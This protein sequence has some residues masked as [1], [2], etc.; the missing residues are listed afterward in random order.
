MHF[1]VGGQQVARGREEEGRVVILARRRLVF[2]DAAAQEVG[3]GFGGQ[4]GEGVVGG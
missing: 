3:F 4:R 2:G 1:A